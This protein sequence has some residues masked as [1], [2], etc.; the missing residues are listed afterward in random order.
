MK[1]LVVRLDGI[2]DALACTPLI[3]VLRSAGHDLGIALTQRNAAV[4]AR[5]T[6][7]WTH[8]LERNP[9]PAHGHAQKDV[10]AAVTAAGGIGYDLALVASEEP[11][12]YI[13]ARRCARR[14]VGFINGWEKPLKSLTTRR[15][16]DHAIVRSAAAK[17][18]R[19]H[20]VETLFRLGEGLHDEPTPPR[21][22]ARLSPLVVDGAAARAPDAPIAVQLGPKWAAMGIERAL[23]GAIVRELRPL[24]P[25][26]LLVSGEEAGEIRALR[27]FLDDSETIDATVFDGDE[28][29]RAWKRAIAEARVLVTTDTGAAHVA[30]MTGTPCV[31]LFP[32]VPWA[33]SEIVRWE[34][35]AAPHACLVAGRDAPVAAAVRDLCARF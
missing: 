8:I 10:E 28:G 22:A 34:P 11:D 12:A 6:F 1:I 30:G 31:D 26:R 2:G 18:A 15:L 27:E 7:A 24:G 35:W 17:R 21:E 19:E 3:A 16:L 14:R 13:L 32:D 5:P 4:F 9:W 25:V 23:L 29:M 20:E 33:R